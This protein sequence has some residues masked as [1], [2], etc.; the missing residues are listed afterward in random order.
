MANRSGIGIGWQTKMTEDRVGKRTDSM[1]INIKL[2]KVKTACWSNTGNKI[3]P[4][5]EG[6]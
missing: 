6:R 1:K 2:I 3:K 5:S 4:Q